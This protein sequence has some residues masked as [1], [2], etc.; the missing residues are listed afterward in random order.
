MQKIGQNMGAN[1][2]FMHNKFWDA[3]SRD[4][5]FTSR[6][7]SKGGVFERC[8]YISVTTDIDAKIFHG[9]K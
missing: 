7:S 8:M 6:K 1:R 3:Q 5:N 2:D 9:C 4:Q